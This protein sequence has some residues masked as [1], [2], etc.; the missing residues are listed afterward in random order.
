MIGL[1]RKI[2]TSMASCYIGQVIKMIISAG[3]RIILARIILPESWGIFAEAML[4]VTMCGAIRDLGIP[5]HLIREK[6]NYYGNALFI[7]VSMSLLLIGL[8]QIFAPLSSFLNADLPSV[9][10]VFSLFIFL[11]GLAVVPK[12]FAEKELII[13]KIIVCEI[14]NFSFMAVVSIWMAYLNYGVWSLVIG[15]LA[16]QSVYTLLSWSMFKKEIPLEWEMRDT[17]YLVW[18]SIPLF[19]VWAF[20]ITWT[21]IDNGIIGAFLTEDQVGYYFMAY[22]IASMVPQRIIYPSI[23][24][25]AYPAMGQLK[26]DSEKLI[27]IHTYATIALLCVEVPIAAF[28]FFNADVIVK[29]ALGEKWLPIIPLIR[30][31]SFA[32]VIYP[33]KL[34]I[35]VLKVLHLDKIVL[36]S[37]VLRLLSLVVFGILLTKQFGTI[38]MAFANLL[39]IGSIPELLKIISLYQK[40]MKQ[41]I[42]NVGKIYIIAFSAFG[43]AYLLSKTSIYLQAG[44]SII[45]FLLVGGL[46]YIIFGE[47]FINYIKSARKPIT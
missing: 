39:V 6:K 26:D 4:I 46:Y 13:K 20:A 27:K 44:L 14:F 43:I 22:F 40:Q 25:V 23:W 8:V 18:R 41:F 5:F 31:L 24:R 16:G 38:G 12:V 11:E 3:T 21:Y 37:S 35:E 32:P 36:L 10:R 45:A 42:I 1:N 33:F 28:L 7:E 15:Q 47:I 19:F 30:I 29:L 2:V 17:G 9:L 34:G